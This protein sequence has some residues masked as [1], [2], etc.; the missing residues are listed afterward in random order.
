MS[1]G[2]RTPVPS[3]AVAAGISALVGVLGHTSGLPLKGASGQ[4]SAVGDGG[5]RAGEG[6]QPPAGRDADTG[7]I[8]ALERNQRALLQLLRSDLSERDAAVRRIV[9]TSARTLGVQ[10][11]GLW[12][13]DDTRT[14]IV[15][16]TLYSADAD[17]H[18]SGAT[19]TAAG[20]PRYFAALADSRVIAAEDAALDPRTAEFADGYLDRHGIRSMLDVP[21]FSEG[22]VVGVLCHEAVGEAR[23]WSAAD[24]E[25]AGSMADLIGTVVEASRRRRTEAELRRLAA[26]LEERVADRTRELE[27][28]NSALTR[29]VRDLEA[30]CYSVSHDLRG[31]LRVI[32]G[33]ATLLEESAATSSDSAARDSVA[34][35]RENTNRMSELLDGL[36]AFFR[37]GNR[38]VELA[39]VDM[40]A[41]VH[42]TVASLDLARGDTELVVGPLPGVVGDRALLGDVLANLLS[43]AFKFS[44]RRSAPRVE[45][46]C[47]PGGD[48][49]VFWVRDNG[50]GFDA[51]HAGHLFEPFQ[52]LHAAEGYRG[53]GVGLA[54]VRRIVEKHGGRAWAESEPARGST[55]LFSLPCDP[56]A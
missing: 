50:V 25:L 6:G 11:V 10:R 53:T 45:V 55:F 8:A 42:E 26:Q 12:F 23:A 38:A 3:P 24:Q 43:N 19:L 47:D 29:A 33:F 30:F 13:F 20:Q 41:L 56:R 5:F 27:S 2:T 21:V 7:R 16:E 37:L 14:T 48:G 49:H 51:R 35:I 15:A 44:S 28:S 32:N 18:E 22:V 36:L 52:R 34:R 31:P 4:R 1:A 17:R 46:G 39:S 54:I 40:G 9:E